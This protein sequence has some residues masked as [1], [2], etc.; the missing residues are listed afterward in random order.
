MHLE[1]EDVPFELDSERESLYYAYP[2]SPLSTPFAPV[3][4]LDATHSRYSHDGS[5]GFLQRHYLSSMR[6]SPPQPRKRA[7]STKP[8]SKRESRASLGQ[9][10]ARGPLT[11]SVSS[12][13]ETAEFPK[14]DSPYSLRKNTS[15]APDH[16]RTGCADKK[17]W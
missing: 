10:D 9:L 6:S 15:S 17:F 13:Q 3:V 16:V 5:S 7:R 8:K 2:R 14:V 4:Q 11:S 12:R 1:T